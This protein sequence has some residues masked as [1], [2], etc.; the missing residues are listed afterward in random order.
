M[1]PEGSDALTPAITEDRGITSREIRSGMS[2]W[3]IT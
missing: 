1:V 3:S 2:V